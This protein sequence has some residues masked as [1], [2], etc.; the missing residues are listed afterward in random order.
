[1]ERIAQSPLSSVFVTDT[2]PLRPEAKACEKIKVHTISNLLGEAI[3][4]SHRGDSVTS[5]FV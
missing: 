2:I 1:V 5:L 4:R 3:I